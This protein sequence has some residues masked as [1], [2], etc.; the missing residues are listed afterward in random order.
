MA[1]KLNGKDDQMRR[2]DFGRF[3]ATA[4]LKASDA[5]EAIAEMLRKLSDAIERISLPRSLK[6]ISGEEEAVQKMLEISRDRIARFR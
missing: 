2:A 4:G 1:L 3:A 6:F 5:D